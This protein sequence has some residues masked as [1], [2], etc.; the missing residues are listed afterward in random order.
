M[1]HKVCATAQ[2]TFTNSWKAIYEN[3]RLGVVKGLPDLVVIIHEK[4][5]KDMMP[6]LILIEMKR[7]KGGVVSKEQQDWINTL[8]RCTGV[9]AM[10]CRGFEEAKQ[11]TQSFMQ[12]VPPLD[13]SF[14]NSLK[15]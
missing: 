9:A 7:Q 6:K 8:N 1:G 2:S 13:L 3:Q 4:Y 12:V 15:K 14:I 5:R 10:I 11:Y